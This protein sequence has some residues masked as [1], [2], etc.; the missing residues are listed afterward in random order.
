MTEY[1]KSLSSDFNGNIILNQFHDEIEANTTIV[2]SFQ[3]IT[4]YQDDVT[5][6]FDSSLSAG[7]ITALNGLVAKHVPDTNPKRE[8]AYRIY[9]E[10]RRTKS[11][12]WILIASWEFPGT[13]VSG[14]I[15][16][17]DI[18]SGIDSDSESYDV[19][20]VCRSSNMSLASGTF[21][22]KTITINTLTL[23]SSFPASSDTIEI[24]VKSTNK[25]KVVNIQEIL[26]WHDG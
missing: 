9:P 19:D 22:N 6:V 3:G 8:E 20:V 18:L 25:K 11:T 17:V 16:Y 13:S 4:A 21:S 10:K 26:F 15:H 23:N 24:M 14:T 12:N 1:I 2:T 5:I 7:E